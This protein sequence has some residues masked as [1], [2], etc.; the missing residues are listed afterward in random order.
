MLFMF[1]DCK[2]KILKNKAV[3]NGIFVVKW[4]SKINFPRDCL[5]FLESNCLH[6]LNFSCIYFA[7]MRTKSPEL[8]Q[9]TANKLKPTA[10]VSS[11]Y[12]PVFEMST[13]YLSTYLSRQI[14]IINKMS[15]S[16]LFF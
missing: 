15:L 5:R 2:R 9:F 13:Q 16:S 12:K 6:S 11:Y 1:L 14:Q 7:F 8:K 4:V 10:P 3:V